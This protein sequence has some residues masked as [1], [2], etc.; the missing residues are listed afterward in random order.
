MTIRDPGGNDYS[1]DELTSAR[2]DAT[3]WD[4]RARLS[5]RESDPGE[6]KNLYH[7]YPEKSACLQ[8]L[9]DTSKAAGRSH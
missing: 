3:D 6:M 9:L 2:R 4:A 1:V 7:Q 5:K 8:P